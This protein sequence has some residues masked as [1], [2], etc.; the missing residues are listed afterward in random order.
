M[1]TEIHTHLKLQGPEEMLPTQNMRDSQTQSTELPRNSEN[2]LSNNLLGQTLD[3]NCA[4]L[5]DTNPKPDTQPHP[6]PQHQFIEEFF[7]ASRVQTQEPVQG[8]RT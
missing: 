1:K 2:I 6:K 5:S 4:L 3:D 7:S 8:S